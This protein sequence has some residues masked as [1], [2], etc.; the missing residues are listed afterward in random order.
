VRKVLNGE[1]YYTV[2]SL[3][4]AAREDYDQM[5]ASEASVQEELALAA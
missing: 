3:L 4:E 2:E 5:I 1:G